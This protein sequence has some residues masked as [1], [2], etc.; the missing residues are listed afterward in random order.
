MKRLS[1]GRLKHNQ[2]T[3]T[4]P[5]NCA[6]MK[7]LASGRLKH[8]QTH[9]APP[10]SHSAGINRLSSGRLKRARDSISPECS[11]TSR[12]EETR[13]RA[14]ETYRLYIAQAGVVHAGMKRLAS[15][16]L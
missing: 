1:S 14:I 15:G 6:G 12:N 8:K 13:L 9:S 4:R 5:R 11:P 7:R 10:N 3:T 2:L 16:R